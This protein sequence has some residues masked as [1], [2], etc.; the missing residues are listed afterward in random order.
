MNLKDLT[1]W[2]NKVFYSHMKCKCG[3]LFFFSSLDGYTIVFKPD[4]KGTPFLDVMDDLV[5]MVAHSEDS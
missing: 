2:E 1:G 4:L 5:T 3:L